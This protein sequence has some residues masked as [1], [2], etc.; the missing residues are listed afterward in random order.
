MQ[1]WVLQA[2]QLINIAYVG[3]QLSPITCGV[4]LGAWFDFRSSL[5]VKGEFAVSINK[6]AEYLTV[7][8]PRPG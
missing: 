8:E 5:V 1:V 3:I 4:T 6:I 2:Y 7:L